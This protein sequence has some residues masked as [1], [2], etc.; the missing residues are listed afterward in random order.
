[1]LALEIS[2]IKEIMLSAQLSNF[3]RTGWVVAAKAA[4]LCSYCCSRHL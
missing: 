1:M 3:P 2:V 4:C